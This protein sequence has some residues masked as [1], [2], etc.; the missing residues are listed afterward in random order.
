MLIS[1]RRLAKSYRRRKV[2]REVSF[3]L[4]AGM[5]V[6]IQGENGAG[7]STLLQCIVGL[8]RPD[9]GQVTTAG[10][11][12]YCPQDPSLIETLTATEHL[13]LFGAGLGMTP[14]R[15]NLRGSELMSR[16]N[17][18]RFGDTRIDA[19]SGGT[20][21]KINL[22]GSLLHEPEVLV[23]DEPYQG[24]D[25]DTYTRFWDYA[26]E[27]RDRGGSVLVVSHMHAE[28]GRFDALVDL[29]D[30]VARASGPQAALVGVR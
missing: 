8:T 23:L 2:L 29:V 22:I 6:G 5:L 28:I 30:G 3:D 13:S 10:R 12:G 14:D 24:F 18:E 7:K 20:A 16:F 4:P 25:H 11:L 27:F 1:I 9:A 21:Q 15:V 26:E 17:C 19:M